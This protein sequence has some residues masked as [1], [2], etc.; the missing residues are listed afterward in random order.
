MNIMDYFERNTVSKQEAMRKERI[1]ESNA[2]YQVK[3]HGG[4][5]WLTYGGNLVCPCAM[6]KDAPVE[7]V[8]KMRELYIDREVK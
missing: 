8:C 4:E 1:E 2:L 6:L 7:A 5:L 3:E